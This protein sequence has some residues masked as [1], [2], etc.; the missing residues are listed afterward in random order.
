[1]PVTFRVLV[2]DATPADD[3]VFIAGDDPAVFGAAYNPS[4]QPMTPV[5]DN[6]WEWTAQVRAG[7]PLLYKYTRGNWETVEQWGAISG[8]GNAD[9][10]QVQEMVRQVLGLAEAPQPDDAADG[11]AIAICHLQAARYRS[12]QNG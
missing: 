6:M 8:Y 12:W 7:T 9:K 1:M 3:I 4:L 10:E 11:V 5:G 2:P